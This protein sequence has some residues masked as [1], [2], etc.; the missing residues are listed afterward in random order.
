MTKGFICYHNEHN[1]NNLMKKTCLIFTWF[2]GTVATVVS[3][4]YFLT[5]KNPQSFRIFAA[6]SEK[7]YH[8]SF[9][10]VP[11]VLGASTAQFGEGDAR[12]VILRNYIQKLHPD[13]PFLTKFGEQKDFV[14]FIVEV[15]DRENIDPGI[16]IA[17]AEQ[18]SNVGIKVP[19]DCYNAWGWGITG[20]SKLCFISW[21]EGI[22]K[23][24]K[25]LAKNY[26]TAKKGNVDVWEMM[27]RYNPISANR[28]GSWARGVGTVLEKLK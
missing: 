26:P 5:L 15:S 6:E 14:D 7:S 20:S 2:L 3:S 16:V 18:E 28:D 1:T 13:S 23:Y 21:E 25:G 10:A 11:E 17:V 22:E 8:R 4:F 24:I 19:P 9:S 12:P 27:K